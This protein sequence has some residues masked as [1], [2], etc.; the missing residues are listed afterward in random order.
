MKWVLIIGVISS[1]SAHVRG[2]RYRRHMSTPTP[3]L[4]GLTGIAGLAGVQRPVVSV[5]RS[6]FAKSEE[7]FPT[8]VRIAA[9]R[10]LF[11]ASEVAHWLERTEHGNNAN[12]V[13]DAAASAAPATFD[14]TSPRDVAVVDALLTLRT[15]TGQ[16]VGSEHFAHVIE[17]ARQVDPNDDCLTTEMLG[18]R[19]ELANWADELADAAYSPTAAARLIEM[20]HIATRSAAGSAGPLSARGDELLVKLAAGLVEE[21]VA[22]VHVGEGITPLHASELMRTTVDSLT[23]IPT[24][25]APGRSVRRRLLSEGTAPSLASPTRT[26]NRLLLHRLP[27]D[28]AV[29]P[30]RILHEIN[31]LALSL[32]AGDRALVLA[33]SW[34]LTDALDAA[35]DRTRADALRS[36]HVRVILRLGPGLVTTAP[37]EALGVWILGSPTGTVAIADRVTAVADLTDVPL[38]PAALQDL[39]SDVAAALGDVQS[40]RA[41]AFRFA[42]I[43]R[44]TS[45][46]ASRGSLVAGI[47]AR[48]RGATANSHSLPAQLDLARDALGS[49]APQAK[50]LATQ[51]PTLPR[52]MLGSLL[53]DRHARVLSG[54]RVSSDEFTPH[55]LVAVTADDLD[56][57]SRIGTQRVDS[58][59]FAARHPSMKL[60]APGDVIFRTSPT[61]RAWVDVEGASVVVYPARV[62]RINRSDPGGLVPE[63]VAADIAASTA[64]AGTWRRWML[65]RF[66]PA[67]I[68]PLRGALAEL[69]ARRTDLARRIAALD[70]YTDL[71][72]AGVAAG[73]VSITE[74]AAYPAASDPKNE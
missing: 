49:D 43:A 22:E 69:A 70:S 33:P 68:H 52:A 41:H 46:L 21:P 30:H 32:E 42:R 25:S 2:E 12:A 53:A 47:A 9:G 50:T 64:G 59:S 35:T 37:R 14:I 6:R 74:P 67:S 55:G 20:R 7:S 16:P 54:V 36:G 23:F 40:A 73:T 13:A 45:L 15:V 1:W 5:W 31:D 19:L 34:V 24:A 71:L 66:A 17:R 38:T 29:D 8:P 65:R 58:L 10:P 26:G 48:P 18:S 3:L 51:N 57:V 60:T 63:V 61:P 27:H 56:D 4:I 28:L 11:D 72:I 62:L 39:L 44:T